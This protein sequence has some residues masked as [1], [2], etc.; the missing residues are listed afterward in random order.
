MSS[1]LQAWI[2]T[3]VYAN[4][5]GCDYLWREEHDQT[6]THIAGRAINPKSSSTPARVKR[7]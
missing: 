7:K 3:G 1:L 5:F 6:Y 4:A 2:G